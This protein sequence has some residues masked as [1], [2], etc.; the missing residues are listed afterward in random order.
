MSTQAKSISLLLYDGTLQGVVSIE[1]SSWRGEM[2]SAPRGSIDALLG[3]G[4]C[5]KYGVYLLLAHNRVYIGQ[6]SDLSKRLS[7]HM[8]GKDW[9]ENAVVLTTKDDS[10]DHTDI[11]WLESTLIKRARSIASLKCDNRQRGNPVKVT[12]FKEAF[13]EPYLNEALF[14]MELIGITVFSKY[15]KGSGAIQAPGRAA[16]VDVT[17]VHNR[18]AFGTRAKGD[19][20][21]YLKEHSVEVSRHNNYANLSRDGSEFFLNPRR[22]SL[23]V[24]W[25]LILNDTSRYE[26]IVL[27]VPAGS[28]RMADGTSDGL[29]SRRDNPSQIDLHLSVDRLKDH[30]SGVDFSQFLIARVAY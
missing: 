10:L 2:Y 11:D 18:L 26:L 21:E 17:N 3:Y 29:M 12:R 27:V 22:N 28:L 8:A 7:Q 23:A 24:D 19:A 20:I 16:R 15:G 5:N 14:L 13:L 25:T 1:D 6:S 4:A 9:W 30:H